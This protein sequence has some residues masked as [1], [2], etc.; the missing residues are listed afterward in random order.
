MK[1]F[2]RRGRKLVPVPE[3]MYLVT[4]AKGILEQL[5]QARRTMQEMGAGQSGQLNVAAM[6]GPVSM[7]FPRFIAKH[8]G[9]RSDIRVSMLARSSTQI[10]E[11][12][13]AQSID[14]G[15]ADLPENVGSEGLVRMD[16]LEGD[17]FLAVPS[18]HSLAAETSVALSQLNNLQMGSLQSNHFHTRAIKDAFDQADLLFNLRVESQTFLPILQFVASG[19]CCAV[20]DPLTAVHLNEMGDVRETVNVLPFHAPIRYRYAV[21]APRHR[22]TSVIAE[23]AREAWSIEVF[24]LLDEI[25]ANPAW[26]VH[27]EEKSEAS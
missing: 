25:G 2:E 5:S 10:S 3:A 4:E 26:Q 13:R 23:Q 27:A 22:P 21:L 7:L 17:C 9:D 14:F 6:P 24:G 18:D 11:L 15:F 8:V 16:V 19:Q 20:L 12:A 1:L